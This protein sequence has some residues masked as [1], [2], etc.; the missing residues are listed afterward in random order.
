MTVAQPKAVFRS[1]PAERHVEDSV[2]GTGR[3]PGIAV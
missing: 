1:R 3:E 2:Q